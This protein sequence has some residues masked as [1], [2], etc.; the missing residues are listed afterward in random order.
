MAAAAAAEPPERASTIQ[1][2]VQQGGSSLS[3]IA[4]ALHNCHYRPYVA[5]QQQEIEQLHRDESLQIPP[6]TD[7]TQLP[8][9]TEDVEKLSA[10]RPATLAQAL[11]ISG[12]TPSAI[13]MLLQLVKRNQLRGPAHSTQRRQLVNA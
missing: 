5:R 12:V 1:D 10:A 6:G 3:H 13:V 9:S 11:R 2:L 8:L 4:T 7:Y